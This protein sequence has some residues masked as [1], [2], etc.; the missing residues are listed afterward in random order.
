MLIPT[1]K[2]SVLLLLLI[3]L[4]SCT[5]TTQISKEQETYF[6]KY[7]GGSPTDNASDLSICSNGE[8]AITGSIITTQSI[9]QAV[10]IRTDKYGNQLAYSPIILSQ[11][12]SSEGRSIY[13][14]QFG[15]LWVAGTIIN[16]T[17][18]NDILLRKIT[19]D[20][21]IAL[22]KNFGSDENDEAFCVKELKNGNIVVGGYTEGAGQ[23]KKDAWVIMLNP[24]A[25]IIW[26]HTFGGANDDIC[27]DLL[28]H[29]D[30]LLLVGSTESFQYDEVKRNIF[31]VKIDKHS[32]NGFDAAW[33]G[34]IHD[35]TAIKSATDNDGNIYIVNNRVE[36]SS[37]NA[38]IFLL[39]L[40]DNLHNPIWQKPISSFEHETAN[41]IVITNDQIVITGTRVSD[42]DSDILV[43][44]VDLDGNIIN[45]E[46][47]TIPAPGNQTGQAALVSNDG[48]IVIA[49]NNSVRGFSKIVLIK[50]DVPR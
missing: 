26:N 2:S 20:G 46:S 50:T 3:S 17:A 35:E 10:L 14:N 27:Y 23:G 34:G 7:F 12:K 45:N 37:D 21:T 29:E 16:G 38:G 19:A 42:S 9:S 4:L 47:T 1:N 25:D 36:T 49:G 5:E 22:S 48:K 8:Y 31:L 43:Y 32:G 24:Q 11:N 39:K 44:V 15:A 33:P 18:K 41:N 40:G 6:F 28:E 30:Y 13:Q